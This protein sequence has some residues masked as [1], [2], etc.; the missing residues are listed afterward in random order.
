MTRSS[1]TYRTDPEAPSTAAP[2]V[3]P[4]QVGPWLLGALVLA[5]VALAGFLNVGISLLE[6]FAPRVL[7]G[8]QGLHDVFFFFA[9]VP[10]GLIVVW[11]MKGKKTPDTKDPCGTP[12]GADAEA[13]ASLTS[14]VAGETVGPR[15]QAAAPRTGSSNTLLE[16][17]AALFF[18][19]VGLWG[20]VGALALVHMSPDDLMGEELH[21]ELLAW[22]ARDLSNLGQ[23]VMGS[24]VLAG[25]AELFLFLGLTGFSGEPAGGRR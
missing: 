8:I 3:S 13:P 7:G 21:R 2:A 17:L 22:M 1:S 25:L 5:W 12:P 10:V 4:E 19:S 11:R 20:L 9:A 23:V 14:A 16:D 6:R 18:V 15:E 24:V